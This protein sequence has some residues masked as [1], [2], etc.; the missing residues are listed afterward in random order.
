M[1]GQYSGNLVRSYASANDVKTPYPDKR[2]QSSPW[3]H[4]EDG[5]DH[6]PDNHQVPANQGAEFE[7]TAIPI[8]HVV[9]GGIL[10]ADPKFDHDSHAV[11]Y[12]IYTDDQGQQAIAAGHDADE[13]RGWIGSHYAAP[14]LQGANEVYS[15]DVRDGF[16][17]LTGPN[18]E[19][20]PILLRG[21]NSYALNNPEREGYVQG[22]RPGRSRSLVQNRLRLTHRVRQYDLQPLAERQALHP[23]NT[24]ALPD[25][26][27]YGPVLPGWLPA[28]FGRREVTPGFWR[29]PANVDDSLLAAP[30][31]P[32]SGVI[33]GD[34]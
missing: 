9:G 13:T 4:D 26:P 14:E 1:A 16:S 8:D 30:P 20:A 15:E 17:P 28:A 11:L 12:P 7:G 10:L 32:D 22:V 31:E 2:H 23:V 6:Y 25:A 27:P 24:P 33:G 21:I 5:S 3:D 19:G 18:T 34:L 29:A